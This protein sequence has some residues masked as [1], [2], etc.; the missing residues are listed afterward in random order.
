VKAT[1]L[2]IG[3]YFLINPMDEKDP[4]G[5]W[6]TISATVGIEELI[7]LNQYPDSIQFEPMPIT[8][9]LVVK[10]GLRKTSHFYSFAPAVILHDLKENGRWTLLSVYDLK[11]V[12][13][14]FHYVHE[15][16][17]LYHGLMAGQDL[18][19]VINET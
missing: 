11:P 10:L 18:P 5:A 16:Q 12:G 3:N 14:C 9:D 1:D 7:F 4:N 8:A 6:V 17:N 19:I 2:R 13:S 15:L